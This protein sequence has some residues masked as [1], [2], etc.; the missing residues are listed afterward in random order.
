[1]LLYSAKFQSKSCEFPIFQRLK[2]KVWILQ[3][4]WGPKAPSRAPRG[5]KGP[6]PSTG[7][8]R[9]GAQHPDLLVI[10]YFTEL[11]YN[12][13]LTIR[14]E[15]DTILIKGKHIYLKWLFYKYNFWL[16]SLSIS[17]LIKYVILNTFLPLYINEHKFS[18]SFYRNILICD[19]FLLF[20]SEIFC[21]NNI[22]TKYFQWFEIYHL[23]ML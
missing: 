11:I 3:P 8:T 22:I 18:F 9:M 14:N 1:M 6:Y 5:L 23:L 13:M 7:A 21:S 17:V 12:R 4:Y 19:H 15:N 2:F 10:Q 20:T 16:L